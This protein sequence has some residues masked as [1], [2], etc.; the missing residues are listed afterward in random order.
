MDDMP[1]AAFAHTVH[2]FFGE[3]LTIVAY[4]P[5]DAE[6]GGAVEFVI[7]G[8]DGETVSAH[9]SSP[10]EREAFAK[11]WMEA[12]RH[13]GGE[14]ATVTPAIAAAA[15][16]PAID[17]CANMPGC[18]SQRV[19][20][21]WFHMPAICCPRCYENVLGAAPDPGS[22]IT[23]PATEV[24]AEALALALS[25]V[26]VAIDPDSPGAAQGLPAYPG[27]LAEMLLRDVAGQPA[28]EAVSRG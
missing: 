8:E 23:I 25:R 9:V 4:A 24:T 2:G 1:K 21:T 11:A 3:E 19:L 10:A 5:V 7:K 17:N 14:L 26:H 12:C 22:V 20:F 6:D 13:A 15:Y 27:T 28:R 18:G 16:D